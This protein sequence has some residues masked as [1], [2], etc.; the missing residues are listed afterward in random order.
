MAF[1][2][3]DRAEIPQP[4]DVVVAVE[5]DDKNGVFTLRFAG[6]KSVTSYFDSL[7]EQNVGWRD[8]NVDFRLGEGD[9]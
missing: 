6:G 3:R 8:R 4:N 1:F 9:G 5:I 2:L 7:L